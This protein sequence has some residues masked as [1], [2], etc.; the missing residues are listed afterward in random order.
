MRTTLLALVTL[1]ASTSA[2]AET[3]RTACT[4]D[5]NA[6]GN[7]SACGCTENGEYNPK[8]GHCLPPGPEAFNSPCDKRMKL[9]ARKAWAKAQDEKLK[10]VTVSYYS[11]GAW[12]EAVSDNT[13]SS[14]VTVV[15]DEDAWAT[16]TVTAKQIGSSD[17]CK[18]TGLEHT[19]ID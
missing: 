3:Q 18:I 17:D 4:A 15:Y 19:G 12:T 9:A 1:I 7:P 11:P 2:W 16:Y 14:E 10:D 8:T 5:V 6:W 13:G